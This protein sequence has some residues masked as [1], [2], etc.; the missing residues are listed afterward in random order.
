MQA[1]LGR[2]WEWKKEKNKILKER[3]LDQLDEQ[4]QP[5]E[6]LCI[7]KIVRCQFCYLQMCVWISS[8]PMRPT[9]YLS[10]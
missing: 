7:R 5:T 2:K 10:T 6:C 4:P 9:G 1:I 3:K 8:R